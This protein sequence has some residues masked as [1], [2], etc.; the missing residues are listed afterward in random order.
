MSK[1]EDTRPEQQLNGAEIL[2]ECLVR[3][4][5]ELI[6]GYPG[7]AV[8]PIY[9]ALTR[10]PQ[11][12]HILTRHEQGAAH[13]ADGYA[14]ATGRVG[15]A[16]ATSGPGA[17][18]LVTGIATAMMDS[19]PV[20]FVTGQVPSSALGSDGFQEADITGVTLPITK[21]SY[22]VTDIDELACSIREAF[23]VARSGRPGPVLIDIPKDVQSACTDF[24]YPESE[25]IL[26]RQSLPPVTAAEVEQ[27]RAM[28]EA[29]T[30]PVILAGHGVAMAGACDQL[31]AL[32]ERAE[33]PVALTLLGKGVLAE[34][35]PLCLGMMGM[36]GTAHANRAIQE[37][38]LLIALG[39]R[40]DDRVTGKLDSYAPDA[41]KLHV[42][43][44][45]AEIN[46][47]VAVD[48]GI[49]GDLY[50][51]LMRLLDSLPRCAHQEWMSRISRWRDESERRDVLHQ[52]DGDRLLASQAIHDL[53]QLTRGGALVVT[54]VGQHQ[55]WTAQYYRQHR[56]HTLITS[57]GMGTMGFGLP[58]AIGAKLGRLS[59][60]VWVIAGD[61]GF[62]MT[63]AELATACQEQVELKIVVIN[64]GYLGMVRQWQELFYEQRYSATPMF[65]PDLCQLAASY[66]IP[67]RR[68]EHRRQIE[69]AVAEARSHTGGPF[70][71]E[72]VVEP[73]DVVYPMVPPGEDLQAMLRRPAHRSGSTTKASTR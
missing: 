57:G 44:D 62:Q 3:E 7:G 1:A 31:K 52:D 26:P 63:M 20:V 8:L 25:V 13:M 60:E 59:D 61:G 54:D 2:L 34:D 51:V 68:V 33:I 46:K 14:R 41:R 55:M 67:A 49:V 58:A 16:F 21:H 47:N 50:Q 35:H 6:F 30:R 24:Y 11:L 43:I 10:Y 72:L 27:A 15:V 69:A 66:G 32:A 23:H 64:N 65:G 18:N 39:M 71:V 73:H 42:D 22:L 29:A 45:A 17:T 53:W 36:H 56:P 19:S 40:F 12:H 38:D 70:L 5:V 48:H 28:I 9:D 37:A 4:G